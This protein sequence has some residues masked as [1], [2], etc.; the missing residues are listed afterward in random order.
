[1]KERGRVKGPQQFESDDNIILR[2]LGDQLMQSTGKTK[3]LVLE[4]VLYRRNS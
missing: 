3:D 1:M 2:E 4:G